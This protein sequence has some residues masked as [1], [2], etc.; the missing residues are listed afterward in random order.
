MKYLKKD[1]VP[2]DG[3]DISIRQLSGLERF[4]FFEY[5]A[6]MEMPE[7]PR[8]PRGETLTEDQEFSYQQALQDNISAWQKI[9]YLGQSRLVA[10]GLIDD[11][12]SDDID[13]R[14]KKVQQ[15]FSASSIKDLHDAIA[16]LSGMEMKVE[17]ET[18]DGSTDPEES[19]ES[20]VSM[21]PKP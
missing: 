16:I 13:E 3:H 14:H 10:Y 17:E 7:T 19:D 1:T 21:D 12:L 4:E 2:I 6:T 8:R 18:T 11:E 20:D 5:L 15:W 9:N